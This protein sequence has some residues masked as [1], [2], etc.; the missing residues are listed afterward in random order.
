[1]KKSA[2]GIVPVK[3]FL[4]LFIFA[5]YLYAQN[6]K[7]LGVYTDK[8]NYGLE[9]I[10]EKKFFE[11]Y[12]REN[13]NLGYVLHPVFVRFTLSND[14]NRTIKRVLS[15]TDSRFEEMKLYDENFLLYSNSRFS[16]NRTKAILP[17]FTVEMQPYSIST[18]L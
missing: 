1:M 17:Y 13:V 14:S 11:P 3:F 12:G 10:V 15:P 16:K 8:E 9:K 2:S 5:N 7:V 6:V 4:L 18:Y